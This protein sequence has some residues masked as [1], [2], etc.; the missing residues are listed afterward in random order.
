MNMV[1]TCAD[2]LMRAARQQWNFTGYVTSDS[3]AVGDI[4]RSHHYKGTAAAASCVAVSEGGCDIDSGNTFNE[5]LMEGVSQGLC[6]V[7]S[8]DKATSSN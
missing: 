6:N 8:V 3:D 1:P 5:G 2:P 4:Y 7:S